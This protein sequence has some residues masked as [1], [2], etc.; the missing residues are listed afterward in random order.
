MDHMPDIDLEQAN[1]PGH[2][3]GSSESRPDDFDEGDTGR[4]VGAIIVDARKLRIRRQDLL[5]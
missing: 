1:G 3:I 5:D 2:P 4:M